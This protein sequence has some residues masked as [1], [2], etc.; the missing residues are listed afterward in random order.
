MRALHADALGEL[1]HLA[2]AEQ[3]LLL[4]VGA[5][6]V[7]ARLAQAERQQVLLDEGLARRHRLGDLALDLLERDLLGAAALELAYGTPGIV[8]RDDG[9]REIVI[10]VP[11]EVWGLDPAAGKLRWHAQMGLTGNVSP[12]VVVDGTTVYV[13]GGF[14]V[15]TALKILKQGAHSSPTSGE[16]KMLVWLQKR[17]RV[18][19][20]QG[21]KFFVRED[22]A[23]RATPM[24][25]ALI[26]VEITDVVFAVDSIPAV[27]AVTTNPFLVFTSNVFAILG[28]RSLYFVLA[29]AMGYFSLLKYG[30]SLVLVF[31]GG[32]QC[33][34]AAEMPRQRFCSRLT[35]MTYA[36]C[37][38]ESGQRGRL[39]FFQ[40][41]KQIAGRFFGHAIH[42]GQV[43]HLQGVEISQCAHAVAV[44]KLI[45]QFVAQAFNVESIA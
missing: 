13:F 2:L 25:L 24:L 19:S 37:V 43:L 5:L 10:A 34:Q 9:G 41:I 29:S 23:W 30:L 20:L 45:D 27:F 26:L 35:D 18:A 11:G 12:S 38:D 16:S 32:K 15:L 36:Q 1:A 7:L 22:G 8:T 21:Q 31:I 33:I 28:L 3:Q 4:Q 44:H 42:V 14:L 17:I 39:G 6:E 40:R